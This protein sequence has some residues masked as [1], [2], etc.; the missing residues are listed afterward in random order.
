MKKGST[1]TKGTVLLVK[2]GSGSASSDRVSLFL[3]L[4]HRKERHRPE[5]QWKRK[6]RRCIL[7]LFLSTCQK[8]KRMTSL[9]A[10]NF[11]KR[12]TICDESPGIPFVMSIRADS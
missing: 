7:R 2:K 4:Q 9:M 3:L 1:A 8:V 12:P 10:M 5:W 11:L 6:E